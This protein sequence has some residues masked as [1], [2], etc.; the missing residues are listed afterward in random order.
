M[1]SHRNVHS[2]LVTMQN[3]SA[4]P[5]GSL[6][7]SYKTNHTVQDRNPARWFIHLKTC[8]QKF[9][10]AIFT[11]AKLEATEKPFS[12]CT[13]NKLWSIQAMKG[14]SALKRDEQSNHKKTG[15]NL[16]STSRSATNQSE[17]ATG[18]MIL[19][20]SVIF[21][22]RRNYGDN[23]EA[24]RFQGLEEERVGRMT[25]WSIRGI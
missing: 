6:S 18:R 2:L 3:G 4:T 7:V 5:G 11:S 23:K 25:S 14:D 10:P 13:G 22:R 17:K 24:S 15:R 20:S 8:L 19:G 16:E 21:Q 1:G 9:L 12:R